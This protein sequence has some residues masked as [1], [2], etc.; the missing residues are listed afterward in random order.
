MGDA[1]CAGEVDDTAIGEFVGRHFG[2][3][4][5]RCFVETW[6]TAS[7]SPMIRLSYRVVRRWQRA[8]L[9]R[10]CRQR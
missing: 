1:H 2:V 4:E 7:D 8:A 6:K 10:C 5:D 3:A 9:R